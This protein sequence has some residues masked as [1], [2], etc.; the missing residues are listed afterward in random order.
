[1]IGIVVVSH[2]HAL[3][4]A[5]L[6][7]AYQMVENTSVKVRVA[8]GLDDT[9][10][11]TNASAIAQAITEVDSTD[12]ILVL[13]DLGSAILSAEMALEFIDADVS[14]RT[15]IS[16]APLVEGLLAALVS[17]SLGASL[18]E[19]SAEAVRGLAAKQQQLGGTGSAE[20]GPLPPTNDLGPKELPAGDTSD[21]PPLV[22]QWTIRNIHGLHARPAARMIAALHGEEASITNTTTGRGP[23]SGMSLT[24]LQILGLRHGDL[25]EVTLSGPHARETYDRL[26]ELAVQDFGEA[27]DEAPLDMSGDSR[28]GTVQDP[29]AREDHPPH[30]TPSKQYTTGCQIVIAPAYHATNQVDTSTYSPGD[31]ASEIER[32]TAAVEMVR[33][34]LLE[35]GQETQQDIME[36]QLLLLDDPQTLDEL[37]TAVREGASGVEVV[38]NHFTTIAQQ[39]ESL[40]DEYLAARGQDQRGLQTLLLRAL[41]GCTNA[42]DLVAAGLPTSAGIWIFDDLDPAT[43]RALDTGICQGIV[44]CNSGASAHGVIIAQGRGISLLTG[45]HQARTITG[46]TLL[47]LD[48]VAQRLWIDPTPQVRARLTAEQETRDQEN[49]QA[50]QARHQPA[51]TLTGR[52]I[53]VKANISS[54][55]EAQEAFTQGAQGAGLVRTEV[56]FADHHQAPTIEEQAEVYTRIGQELGGQEIT[57]RTWD[58]GG[59]KLLSFLAMDSEANPMLGERGIRAMK[60][61]PDIFDAQLSACLLASK[62]TP[63]RV[64][65]PMI[66]LRGEMKWARS[67]LRELSTKIGASMSVGMMVE[68]PAAAL[69]TEDFRGLA[70]FISLG[71]NDLTAYTLAADRGNPH[72]GDLFQS[73]ATPVFDLM[74]RAAHGFT[75][76]PIG[77]CGDLASDPGMVAQL[78]GLGATELSVRTAMVSVIKAAVR[79]V[80]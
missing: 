2:S 28:G 4:Q 69:R 77:V 36:V 39:M 70:D 7:L 44:V 9:T 74:A 79:Q 76:L 49:V 59:D 53:A 16:P 68:T 32:L 10:F 71:T 18:E 8:A 3:G 56:L 14:E 62:Q 52:T 58:P 37:F 27:T 78:I 38:R 60:R 12:G 80:D 72:T 64:M 57:I 29:P 61:F 55:A 73:D 67:R 6:D 54:V 34:A 43:A 51:T 41:M 31:P 33:E 48:P 25:M 17:A 46:G 22:F 45:H 11:G 50:W 13:V 26:H 1:M 24:E 66:T 5:A 30:A 47:G 65:F 42:R 20:D 23:A 35:P 15:V 21:E 40:D 19:V 63:L 75:G